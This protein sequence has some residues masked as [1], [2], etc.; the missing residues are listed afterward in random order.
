ML[1]KSYDQNTKNRR[2][3]FRIFTL[4]NVMLRSCPPIYLFLGKNVGG[5]D[6]MQIIKI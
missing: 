3:N 4:N 5:H 1:L 6:P 2:R